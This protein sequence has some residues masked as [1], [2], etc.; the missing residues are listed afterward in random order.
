VDL[1]HG[2]AGVLHRVQGLLV[3]VRGFDAVDL[4]FDL[5]DLRGC[6]LEA[7]LVDFFAAEGGF[8]GCDEVLYQWRVS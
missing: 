4:L 6:L 7:A 8:R 2:R 5:G 1:L 3:D